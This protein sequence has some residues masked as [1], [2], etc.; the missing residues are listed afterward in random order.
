MAAKI[1]REDEVIV[2][3]G[4]DKGKRGKV[5][6]V[7]VTGKVVVEGIN[8]VKKHTKPNPQLGITGGI[9]EKEAA[10]QVSNVAI[11]N[12]ATGKADRVGFRFEDGKKV[13]FFKSNGELVK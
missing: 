2:L 10:I 7:L 8:L 5:T 9:V 6:R 11:F 12:P 1:R 3:T 13:R 4:K